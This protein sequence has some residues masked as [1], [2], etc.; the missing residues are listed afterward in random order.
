[1]SDY[2]TTY[3]VEAFN[4][5]TKEWKLIHSPMISYTAENA[6]K[7]AA[8]YQKLHPFTDLRYTNENI[9]KVNS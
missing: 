9:T 7:L 8:R 4:P 1:M 2:Q 6:D 5:K 3:Q